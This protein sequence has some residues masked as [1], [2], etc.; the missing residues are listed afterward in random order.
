MQCN[1]RK[2]RRQFLAKTTDLQANSE[3]VGKHEMLLSHYSHLQKTGKNHKEEGRA[4]LRS[5]PPLCFDHKSTVNFAKLP[6][7][8]V[9]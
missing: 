4:V 3:S 5:L 7:E 6:G 9:K 1:N 8:K 2:F